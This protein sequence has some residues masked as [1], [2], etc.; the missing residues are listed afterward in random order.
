MCKRHETPP[1]SLPKANNG[2]QAARVVAA[3]P[4]IGSKDLQAVQC[5]VELLELR[6]LRHHLLLHEER[7]LQGQAVRMGVHVHGR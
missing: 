4:M 6:G 5:L 7:R 3:V 1:V 2:S